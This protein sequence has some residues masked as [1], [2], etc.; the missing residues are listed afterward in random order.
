MIK[1]VEGARW[2]NLKEIYLDNAATTAALSEVVAA[3]ERTLRTS[4]G[5]PSSLHAKGLEAERLVKHARQIVASV[6]NVSPRNIV[7][8]SGGTEAN[9][10]AIKGLARARARRGRHIVT[11]AIEHPSVL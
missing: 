8:T 10:L 7:F 11:S 6:L 2:S 9:H 4:Y 5:N 1:S 3:I